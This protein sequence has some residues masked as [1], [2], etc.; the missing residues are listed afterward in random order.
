[1]NS[2]NF[3]KNNTKY[4]AVLA[5]HSYEMFGKYI[6]FIKNLTSNHQSRFLDVGCGVGFVVDVIGKNSKS[7]GIDVSDLF[8]NKC[9]NKNLNCLLYDGE[10]FPLKNSFFDIVGSYNVLEHVDN[11]IKFLDE[12]VRVLSDGGYLIIACPNFL[13][14]S[15]NYHWHTKG[16]SRKLNNLT[17]I[18]KRI[19]LKN[20][21]FEKM[22]TIEREDFHSDD[23]ACNVINHI[24]LYKWSKNKNLKLEYWSSQSV[25]KKNFLINTIDRTIFKIFLGSCFFVFKKMK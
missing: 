16:V 9:K 17:G 19:F 20:F 11:P 6:D 15:N 2:K 24:D 22:E 12:Q 1:M 13:S 21:Y 14:I 18:V 7:Y 5:K 10:T 23:D 25:Y 4:A 3:Y 8:I